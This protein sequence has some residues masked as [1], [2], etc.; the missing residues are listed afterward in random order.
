[1]SK[2]ELFELIKSQEYVTTLFDSPKCFNEM[3][4]KVIRI[5]E[6]SIK[7]KGTPNLKGNI[8]EQEKLIYEAFKDTGVIIGPIISKQMGE[9]ENNK[10]YIMFKDDP[11]SKLLLL[12]LET[13]IP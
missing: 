11:E 13:N 3:K 12:E 8:P 4:C 5:D 2:E 6:H 1:M 7:I 9:Y 10:I